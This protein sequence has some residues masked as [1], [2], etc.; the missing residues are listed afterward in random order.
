VGVAGI[1]GVAIQ[2]IVPG[3]TTEHDSLLNF[4]IDL[5]KDGAALASYSE[6]Q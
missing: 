2:Q 6:K 1:D 4:P 5:Q 3:S